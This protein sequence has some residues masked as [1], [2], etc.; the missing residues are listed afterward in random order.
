MKF[1]AVKENHLY[2]KAYSKGKKF[3]T[4]TVIVYVMRDFS[5]GRIANARP[6]KNGSTVSA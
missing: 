3:V 6:D 2:S 1:T 4:P 5:A